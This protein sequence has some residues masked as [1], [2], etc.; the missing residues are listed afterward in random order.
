MTVNVL[1]QW[2][3]TTPCKIA[4]VGEAPGADEVSF[5]RPFCGNAGRIFDQLL[6]CANIERSECLVTNVFDEKLPENDV[7]NWC[8]NTQAKESSPNYPLR[9]PQ[10]DRGK[11]LHPDHIHHIQ[12]L[13]EELQTAQPTLTIPLGGTA[14]WALTGNVA[15]GIGRVKGTLMRSLRRF[16]DLKLM[17]M[18]HPAF[19]FH[20]YKYFMPMVMWMM[21]AKDEAESPEITYT[22][23]ELWLEPTLDDILQF[24]KQYLIDAPYI[25][26]DIE[27]IPKWRHIKSVGFSDG[28][29]H[30]ICI[31]FTDDRK[32]N[33]S[34]WSTVEEEVK[35]WEYISW[36]CNKLQPK[37]GQNFT[38]DLRW[39]HDRGIFVRNA[40]YDTRLEHHALYP[41]LDKDLGF[42][43]ALYAKE[44]AW[45][46]W[47]RGEKRDE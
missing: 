22:E 7:A 2:P 31:P 30:A 9:C 32:T 44:R 4:F 37:A 24:D 28:P 43:G 27:T 5:G 1:R 19:L 34:Y 25:S 46:G 14:L 29:H 23:R 3:I 41:E 42:L 45:K 16:G 17:P 47:G 39:L 36:I 8:I 6:R 13:E 10:I 33:R 20:S 35:A 38:Y 21:K 12:R 11:W 40:L 15:S 18:Y 26:I